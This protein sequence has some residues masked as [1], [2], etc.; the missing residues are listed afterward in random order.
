MPPPCHWS[1][2]TWGH[3]RL[4]TIGIRAWAPD[5]RDRRSFGEVGSRRASP[6]ATAGR[7]TFRA[8][9]TCRRKPTTIR[10]LATRRSWLSAPCSPA[11]C[12]EEQ[13][14]HTVGLPLPATRERPAL[15]HVRAVPAARITAA[16]L[17]CEIARRQDEQARAGIGIAKVT[18]AQGRFVC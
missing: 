13:L 6:S 11:R 12:P 4:E 9:T 7:S 16:S 14:P 1:E 17:G 18:S 10:D 15:C 2:P 5:R 8:D 3:R